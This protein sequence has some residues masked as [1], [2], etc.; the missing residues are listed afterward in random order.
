MKKTITAGAVA[1]SLAVLLTGCGQ[2]TSNNN[3]TTGNTTGSNGTNTTATAVTSDMKAQ[4]V[5]VTASAQTAIDDFVTGTSLLGP[6][7][8]KTVN[9]TDYAVV[10][11]S[12][13]DL[14]T[15]EKAYLDFLTQAQIN[16]LFGHVTLKNGA[17]MFQPIKDSGDNSDWFNAK[18]KSVTP[19]KNGYLVTLSVPQKDGSAAQTTTA[20]I[21]KNTAGHYVYAGPNA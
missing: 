12:K 20:M 8:T 1:L 3:S 17:Y 13:S 18:V 7:D 11:T 14:D 21:E 9:G 4:F 16:N 19:E 2:S 10:A 5:S 15:L 6:M